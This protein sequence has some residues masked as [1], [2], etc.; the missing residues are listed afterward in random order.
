MERGGVRHLQRPWGE[1]FVQRFYN[2]FEVKYP[3]IDNFTTDAEGARFGLATEGWSGSPVA[4]GKLMRFLFLQVSPTQFAN[5]MGGRVTGHPVWDVAKVRNLGDRFLEESLPI[6]DP[7]RPLVEKAA[8]EGTLQAS[9]ADFSDEDIAGICDRRAG[10]KDADPCPALSQGAVMEK[11][12]PRDVIFTRHLDA[13]YNSLASAGKTK[14]RFRYF[15]MSHTHHA[16]SGFDPLRKSGRRQPTVVNTGVWQR[17]VSPEEMTALMRARG[18]ATRSQALKTLQLEDL[19]PCYDVILVRPYT[20]TP[21]T[22]LHGWQRNADGK[23]SLGP[24]CR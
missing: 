8:S 14:Q 5:S 23:W 16:G 13:T 4:I 15:I 24:A 9:V 18:I 12:V 19:P 20:D 1:Q 21:A 11:A 3:V 17:V 22:E 10:I 2:D 7:L 6:G